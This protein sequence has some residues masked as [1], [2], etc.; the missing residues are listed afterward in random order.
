MSSNP[1]NISGAQFIQPGEPFKIM[2][3]KPAVKFLSRGVQPP[4]SVY[5]SVGDD[6]AVAVASSLVDEVVTFSYRLLRF[7]GELV[8]GQFQVRPASNRTVTSYQ[9]SLAEGFLL[10]VSCKAA[11]AITRGQTFARVFLT[12]PALGG[13]QPSY[14][15]MADYVTNTMAPAHP[16]GRCLAP[17]E[18]PGNVYAFVGPTPAAGSDIFF[19]QPVNTRW[20]VMSFLADLATSAVIANR[21]ITVGVMSFAQRIWRAAAMQPVLALTIAEFSAAAIPPTQSPVAGVVT[22]A[23]PPDLVLIYGGGF[24]TITA[25][26]DI[27][28]QWS[29]PHVLVEEWLDNV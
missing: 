10:S 25:N 29:A 27:G 21:Q 20:R 22:A 13:G 1:K 5:V 24:T 6:L 12:D 19:Q 23:I 4:S 7:D 8:L 16:G 14:M 3:A 17:S 26:L 2:S 11:Q 18:G 9:E 28:D 15:L